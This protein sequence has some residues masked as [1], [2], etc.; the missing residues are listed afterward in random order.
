MEVAITPSPEQIKRIEKAKEQ[1]QAL[2]F[3]AD[4][5]KGVAKELRPRLSHK[6]QIQAI[7]TRL[8]L[9]PDGDIARAWNSISGINA[10]AH[11][12]RALHQSFVVDDA[13]RAD[14]QAPFDTVIRGLMI[15]LQ[16]KYAAFV[17]R[18]DQ[19]V[20]M[21]DRSAAVTS[22][23]KEIPGALPLLWHFFNKLETPDWL[24]HLA[25]RN[26]LSAPLSQAEEAGVDRS[27]LRQWPA[28]RYLLRMAKSPDA[29]ARALIT[30]T[31]RSVAVST[32]PDVQQMGM[33]ILAALPANEAAPLVDLAEAWL[34]P[35]ARFIVAQGPHDLIK[36]LAQDCEGD[37]ALRATR[38][39]FK[40]FA[41][42]ERLATLFSRHMYEHHLPDAIKAIAPVC[43]AEA[44]AVVADL[45]DQAVR[46]ARKVTDDPPHDY[47]YYLSGEV[48]EHGTKHDV[49]D[50]LVGEI[51][52]A[53]KL[54]IEADPACTRDVV[55]RI[56]SRSPKIFTRISLHVLS[57]NPGGAPDLAQACLAD[58][59]LI[60]ET[61]CRFEY[62]ELARAWFP[63]L[64]A[65]NQQ[66]ILSYVD[67]VPDKY[68]DR[69]NERFEK[70]EKRPP[71][72][73]EQRSR[74][75]SV[76]RDLLWHWRDVLPADRRDRLEQLGDPDAWRQRLY[77]PAKSPATAPDF[78]TT[79]IDEIVAYLETWRPSS[80]EQRETATALAQ[81]LRTATTNNA[82]L[83]SANAA[84]FAQLPPIYV[85]RVL[86]GLSNASNNKYDLDWNGAL[87]LIEAVTQPVVEPEP[88]GIEGDDPDWSW[89]RKAAI[90]LLA[91][92]L[93][94]GAEGF[95]FGAA[96][97]VHG[98]ILE[99]YRTAPREPDTDNFEESYRSFP[100]FGAQSTW[101]GA[102]VELAILFIFWI[103]K[104][105]DS[106]VGKAPR[107]AFK[108][109]PELR[110]I[111]EAELTDRSP[112]GRI[113]RAI[114]GRYLNWF[115]YFAESWLR[116][117]MPALFPDDDLSLRDAAWLAH[118][119]ADSGPISGFATAMRDC[120]VTE[121]KR[122][123][124]ESSAR[125]KQH[126]D[127][128]LAEYLI[129]LYIAAAFADD[130]FA[131]FWDTAPVQARQH[132]MWFLGVQLELRP[133]QLP[134]DL[135]ARALSY[136][137]RRLA[138]AKASSTPDHFREEIG[139]VGQFFFR[140]GIPDEWLMEQV[141]LMSEGGFAPTESYSV[142]DRLEK[143][144]PNFPDLAAQTLAALVKNQHFDRWVYMTQS[145]GMRTIFVNGLATASPK[146]AAAVSEAIN[147]LVAIGDTGY[148]DLLPNPQLKER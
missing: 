84:R 147:Y 81:D 16:G 4:E 27:F 93:R 94:R 71:T 113:P 78:L 20:A 85:R 142:M 111:F 143:I 46:I 37:A 116:G 141:L 31:L 70:H 88:S 77:E 65:S 115:A 14:W 140:K 96:G 29:K 83:Y 122:L 56:Q 79:P 109:L 5:I 66:S 48:S 51:V 12:G 30:D 42:N 61:W 33:E 108:K 54:A 64:A 58:P 68:R 128:R 32:H 18:I 62:G 90:G 28:G 127:D 117:Q 2:G 9:A 114:M 106:E 136:W 22:L 107:E 41:E 39:V 8:G 75:E 21:K 34:T 89:T 101:R 35:D 104:D 139:A 6:Q 124:D 133:D 45:L 43:K 95:P 63:S 13:F 26:L 91:F 145:A 17:Q 67:S 105:Q 44:V 47:T 92:G 87:A 137:D 103:S 86:E 69:F 121:I 52:R 126:V 55:S 100:H 125:D 60:E 123:G 57:I 148:L 25:K 138:A 102:A 135:R 23:S 76:V 49:I 11:G 146:T 82:A 112:S 131:L 40:V 53:S 74:D 118:L 24:P 80:G 38:A 73:E 97:L 72:P 7:V 59:D 19:L 99:L 120:Y 110:Q 130:V 129:I 132:A 10:E 119:S 144:S 36:H 50:A 15:A 1:L 98:L 134:D 3:N